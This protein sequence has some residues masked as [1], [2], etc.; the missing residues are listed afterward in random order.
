MAPQG[1]KMVFWSSENWAYNAQTVR[2]PLNIFKILTEKKGKK[3]QIVLKE[4]WEK[5]KILALRKWLIHCE[6]LQANCVTFHHTLREQC[7]D[8]G[9][10]LKSDN[11][12]VF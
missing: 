6:E 12:Q 4:K 10:M 5:L 3:F 1:L 7:I 9:K 11:E 2:N 8:K